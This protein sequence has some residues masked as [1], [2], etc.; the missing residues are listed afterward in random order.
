MRL[1]D[2]LS[3]SGLVNSLGK[4]PGFVFDR[5]IDD[6][7][8]MLRLTRANLPRS[9]FESAQEHL[10]AG[11]QVYVDD[12]RENRERGT[13]DIVYALRPMPEVVDFDQPRDNRAGSF[14][15]GVT[16]SEKITSNFD[17]TP[18][19]LVAGQTGGGKST[20][21]RQLITSVYLRNNDY[22]FTLIDLKG[23]LEFQTFEGLPR[24]KVVS[25][26]K[27][28]AVEL[29]SF[30]SELERRYAL[31]KNAG[32]KD[33]S[34]YHKLRSK[35]KNAFAKLS[36]QIIVV[37]E[38]AELFLAGGPL[39]PKESQ[40]ARAACSKIA[41]LGRAV[42]VHFIAGTQRPDARALDTQIKGQLTGKVCFQMG[43]TAS[44]MVV[45]SNGRA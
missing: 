25:E 26:A 42:G 14:I 2:V 43:D 45:L 33:I 3:T 10:E 7:T 19:L 8:R 41:R 35:E 4:F 20:F 18:H 44:S 11:L 40:A 15:V 37:D 16:R 36:R 5:P 32:C 13:V 28:S 23:G 39:S 17:D 34:S 29:A 38:I 24:I 27:L 21:L 9:K 30:E 12:V 6:E 22:G 1:T 31:L